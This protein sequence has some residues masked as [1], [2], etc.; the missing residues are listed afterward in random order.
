M[1]NPSK[2]WLFLPTLIA[3]L[4]LMPSGRVSAQIFTNLWNFTNG[5]DGTH[6]C[7][8]VILSGSSLYGTASGGGIS[9]FGAVFKVNTDGTSFTNLYSFTNVTDGE[10]PNG[11]LIL[12]SNTLYGTTVNGGSLGGGTVFAVNTDGTGFTNLCN[13]APLSGSFPT[14]ANGS[15]PYAGLVLSSNTLYGTAIFGA[16]RA[17]RL[18]S[19][20]P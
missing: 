3:G 1:G 20:S 19:P 10:D 4:S 14:N 18:Y 13:F 9:G 12:V 17:Q 5:I 6:P 8:G 15:Y 11:G 2:S 16:L 7:G